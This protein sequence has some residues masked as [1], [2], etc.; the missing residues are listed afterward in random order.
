MALSR[1]F[2]RTFALVLCLL[3][4]ILHLIML[5]IA[6]ATGEPFYTDGYLA[7]FGFNFAFSLFFIQGFFFIYMKTFIH[8]LVAINGIGVVVSFAFMVYNARNLCKNVNLAVERDF[9]VF[10]FGFDWFGIATVPGIGEHKEIIE[11]LLGISVVNFLNESV[12][13]VWCLVFFSSLKPK[14]DNKFK[15][16]HMT[17]NHEVN[18]NIQIEVS[19]KN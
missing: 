13:F 7:F 19:E 2:I 15:Q 10:D 9:L 4:C 3:A 6:S 17:E 12:L 18:D 11:A 1:N 8:E 16:A 14:G 5:I